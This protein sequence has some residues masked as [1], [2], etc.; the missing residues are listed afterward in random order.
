MRAT[1]RMVA[2]TTPSATAH[3]TFNNAVV[4]ATS[5]AMARLPRASC[6][7]CSPFTPAAKSRHQS[8]ATWAATLNINPAST[9]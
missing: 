7:A 5:T 3:T 2:A 8:S 9:A 6:A 1:N 4:A